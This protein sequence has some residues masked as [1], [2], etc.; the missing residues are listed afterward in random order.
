ML[1][2]LL[3]ACWR[4]CSEEAEGGDQNYQKLEKKRIRELG[5]H[6]F[7]GRKSRSHALEGL[8]YYENTSSEIMI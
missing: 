2:V 6:S 5:E 8:V 3:R 7:R 4:W 1:E